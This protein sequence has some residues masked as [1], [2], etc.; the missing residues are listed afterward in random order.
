VQHGRQEVCE[1]G[2]VRL[3]DNGTTTASQFEEASSRQKFDSFANGQ[4]ADCISLRE[5]RLAWQTGAGRQFGQDFI[6]EIVGDRIGRAGVIWPVFSGGNCSNSPKVSDTFE[7]LSTITRS[8]T[9]AP[10]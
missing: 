4:T 1:S 8:L 5:L 7:L 3:P 6:G 9:T 10:P 2:A